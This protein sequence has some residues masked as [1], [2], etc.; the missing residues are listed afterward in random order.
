MPIRFSLIFILLV[1][2][3][4]ALA[5]GVYQTPRD[6][7]AE[8]FAGDP[9]KPKVLWITKK[10]RPAVQKIMGHKLNRL[11]IRYWRRD[12]RSA[13]VLE[14]IGKEK[15]ITV[16]LIVKRDAQG[17]SRLESIRVLEYRESRGDEVRQAFFRDQFSGA[18]LTADQQLDRPIDG[19]SGAT[20]SVRALTKLARLALFLDQ[21]LDSAKN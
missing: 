9:P 4:L 7:V 8:A 16:G 10:L 21:Q 14:E 6:F 3:S 5:R 18:T 12:G 19:I 17:N 2:S 1:I 15:P 13:W 11:R 20:L